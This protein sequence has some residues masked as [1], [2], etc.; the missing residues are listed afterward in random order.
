MHNKLDIMA[1]K[2]YVVLGDFKGPRISPDEWESLEYMDWQS[3]GDTNFAPLAAA[4]GE[5]AAL[6]TVV[7]FTWPA[8]SSH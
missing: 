6:H 3:G 1:E 5:M 7:P 4:T 8:A 2:G